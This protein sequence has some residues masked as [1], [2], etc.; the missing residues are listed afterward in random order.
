[1]NHTLGKWEYKPDVGEVWAV[2]KDDFRV[3]IVDADADGHLIAA[4]PALL[5]ACQ[6]A[7]AAVDVL[8]DD[9]ALSILLRAAIAKAEGK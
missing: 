4:A 2:E 1:V 7:V 8:L 5:L 3:A 9:T 6:T